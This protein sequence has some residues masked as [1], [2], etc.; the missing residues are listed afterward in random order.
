MRQPEKHSPRHRKF[1]NTLIALCLALGW[2][3]FS[4]PA[5]ENA[6]EWPGEA[7][8]QIAN[9][10]HGLDFSDKTRELYVNLKAA[11][12]ID[13][14]RGEVLYAKNAEQLR[15]IASISKLLMAITLL[16]LK[17]NRDS[18][19]AITRDDMRRSS[20]SSFY[21]G[22]LVRAEDLFIASLVG[23]DNRAARALGRTFGGSYQ[24]FAV[25]M[26]ATALRLGL[27]HTSVVEPTG[28]NADNR[29]TAADCAL[30]AN[31]ALMYPEIVNASK[32]RR[33]T[34]NVTNRQ[35]KP[36]VRKV[37]AT[38][39]LVYSRYKTLIAKT[40]Y[41]RASDYCLTTI[42]ENKQGQRLT[43]V[44]LGA[45]WSR[46]RFK[47]ARRLAEFGFRKLNKK[48]HPAKS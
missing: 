39:L 4:Y 36:R 3:T 24:G 18:L 6:E 8:A 38:N 43:I 5:W 13:N 2:V 25:K 42:L 31:R 7:Q 35:G 1:R 20:K 44:A 32:K 11:L 10:Q 12:V 30:L 17:Y 41:I 37:G 27:R 47:E 15:S 29:S 16:D 26:N 34:V 21:R 14:E 48:R 28:L 45:P 33:H 19:I 9:S 46:T 23:S 40:G 22:D